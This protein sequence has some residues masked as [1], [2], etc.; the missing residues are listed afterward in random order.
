MGGHAA[1]G[2]GGA[3]D[4]LEGFV[5]APVHDDSGAVARHLDEVG[6][7]LAIELCLNLSRLAPAGVAMQQACCSTSASAVI[8]LTSS[9][10]V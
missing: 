9:V 1:S 10:R 3:V 5:L 2:A 6:D 4:E 8:E 7:G